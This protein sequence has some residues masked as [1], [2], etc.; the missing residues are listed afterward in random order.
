MTTNK[1]TMLEFRYHE[2]GEAEVQSEDWGH[3]WIGTGGVNVFWFK[4]WGQE[5]EVTTIFPRLDN[6]SEGLV[7]MSSFGDGKAYVEEVSL[8]PTTPAEAVM[9]LEELQTKRVM[10]C[11]ET[12][13]APF[14]R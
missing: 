3:V 2:N 7:V 6:D 4:P 13:V 12:L 11:L 1:M 10:E 14:T 8:E 9:D 5:L